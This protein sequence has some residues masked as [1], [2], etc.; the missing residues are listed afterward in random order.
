MS[1]VS[2]SKIS[3]P[4]PHDEEEG[5]GEKV[6]YDKPIRLEKEEGGVVRI[7]ADTTTEPLPIVTGFWFSWVAAHP[8]TELFS[9]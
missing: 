8:D 2:I 3:K 4:Q 6:F 7:F 5:N 1:C 9:K